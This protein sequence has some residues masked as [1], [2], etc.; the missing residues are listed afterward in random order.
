MKTNGIQEAAPPFCIPGCGR[1]VL[2]EKHRQ[3]DAIPSSALPLRI[4]H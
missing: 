1:Q 4:V 3:F 2:P